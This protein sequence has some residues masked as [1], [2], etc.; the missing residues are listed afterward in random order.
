[1]SLSRRKIGLASVSS[2]RNTVNVAVLNANLG[3]VQ[4]AVN[5]LV[6]NVEERDV[7]GYW[8]RA[9]FFATDYTATLGVQTVTETDVQ[10]N[11]YF[12]LG[13]TLFW[14]L[15]VN[16]VTFSVNASA[17]V[18]LPDG[19]V[20]AVTMYDF[21]HIIN[22]GVFATGVCIILADGNTV[23]VEAGPVGTVF[24]AGVNNSG[25]AFSLAIPVK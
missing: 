20:S 17:V 8:Q 21:A 11:H 4:T 19:L 25:Y 13:K 5:N 6:E 15:F 16:T 14:T 18:K 10:T 9:P 2:S 22:A 7:R 12:V 1:M 24:N 3:D 23:Q